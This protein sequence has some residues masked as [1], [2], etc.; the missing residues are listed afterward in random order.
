MSA[1]IPTL[2]APILCS[3]TIAWTPLAAFAQ[4]HK[5][6]SDDWSV[7]ADQVFTSDGEM[8]KNALVRVHDGKI[9]AIVPG[10]SAGSSET[11]LRASAM[12][13]GMIDLSARID[14]GFGSVEQAREISPDARVAN[15]IDLFDEEWSRAARSGVT[16]VLANPQDEDVIGGLGIALKTAGASSVAAR[17][18]KADAVLRGA[19]GTQPSRRNHPAFGS[20]AD[21]YSRRP[22]TRMGVEWEWRKA[23]YDAAASRSDKSRAYPGSEQVLLALDD[24][25]PLCIQAWSTQDIRT[26]IFLKEEIEREKLG[27]PRLILDAAAEAWK[28]P[29]L[30]VRS[31]AMVVLPPLPMQGRTGE[32][33]F[34][35]WNTA[36]LLDD[37]GVPIAL[38]AHGAGAAETRLDRQAGMAMRGGL[39]FEAALAAVTITPAKMIGIDSRVGSITVGKDADLVLW[40]GKPFELSSGVIGV[41]V[42][43]QLVLD[44]RPA[45]DSASAK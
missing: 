24:K 13:A 5:E 26:A 29:Q 16:T 3:L 7:F 32:G 23:M 25:L 41:L 38:S 9:A 37:L 45:K 17:T 8:I 21:I 28:E 22:T 33:S 30:I 20:P 6:K 42:D 2:A 12:T 14:M 35:A 15:A 11:S 18:V 19:I 4:D 31:K 44:P 43:G 27:T 10:G 36:K 1:T 34:M 39:S 40:S